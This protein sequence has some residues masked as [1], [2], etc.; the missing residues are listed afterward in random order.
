MI[1]S[2]LDFLI[3]SILLRIRN[4]GAFDVLHQIED[5]AIALA[6]RLGRRRRPG[7]ARRLRGSCRRAA[8]TIRTFMRCSG[9]WMPGVSRNTTCASGIVRTPR[10]RFRVVCGLSETIA[11][12]VPTS[13]L[14]SVDLPAFGPADERDEA[15]LHHAIALFRRRPRPSDRRGELLRMIRT[16]LIR[17]RSTSSTSTL[18]PSISNRS[19][20][21]GTR[22]RCDSR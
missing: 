2:S 6:R 10:I 22:P 19:P 3:R 7:R 9:R 15:G 5:E 13:R 12:L 11:S 4:T 21:A 1:G 8:S 17:R 20:T 14:S 16:L 18:R